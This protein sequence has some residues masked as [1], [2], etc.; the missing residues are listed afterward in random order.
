MGKAAWKGNMALHTRA[1][2]SLLLLASTA[3]LAA[4]A[5]WSH[6][7]PIARDMLDGY[8][9]AHGV[10]ASY[11]IRA[12]ETRR[13]R[14]EQ[15]RI[16]DPKRPDL[17]ADW[18]EM[19]VGPSLTG[20]S[21]KA[22][23]AGGVRLWGRQQGE[24]ISFGD[25]DRLLPASS[26][27]SGRLPRIDLVL[28]D[29][30]MAIESDYGRLGV[31]LDGQGNLRSGFEGKMAL[32][33]PDLRI[34]NCRARDVQAYGDV[35]VVGA[36]PT[37]TGPLRFAAL[38]CAG[39]R[40]GPG[41]LTLDAN[42]AE[43][44]RSWRGA[45]QLMLEGVSAPKVRIARL[46]GGGEF[47]GDAQKMTARFEAQARGVAAQTMQAAALQLA[48]KAEMGAR[49]GR[50][51][52]RATGLGITAGA[53]SVAAARLFAGFSQAP[54]LG[55]LAHQ[56]AG[57]VARVG[58]GVHAETNFAVSR[59]D[60][61]TS[62]SLGNVQLSAP[63]GAFITWMGKQALSFDAAGL[64]LAGAAR[65]GGGGFPAGQAQFAG[66]AG[67]IT[68][69]PYRATGAMLRA[70]PISF[71]L[72][73]IGVGLDTQLTLDGP[74]RN[75]RVT[76]LSFP[77]RL[78]PGQTM[79]LGCF[80]LR[81]HSLVSGALRMGPAQ[82][83]T[84]STRHALRLIA[85]RLTG[86]FAGAPLR[87]TSADIR[88]ELQPRRASLN[89]VNLS[90]GQGAETSHLTLDALTG[91]AQHGGFGGEIR[92]LAGQLSGI[93]LAVQLE[94]GRW[95]SSAAGLHLIG[96]GRVADR[97]AVPRFLPLRAA[98]IR[99][100]LAGNMLTA[101]TQLREPVSDQSIAT[102]ALQ[103]DLGH[104]RG[105]A[106]I[107]VPALVFS[108][109]LQPEA[110]TPVTKGVV[111]NVLGSI[112]GTGRIDWA[113]GQVRSS[114]RFQSS[115]LDFAAA[116]GPV[117]GLS[118]EI[119]FSDLIGLVTDGV[120]QARVA[121]INPGVNVTGGVIRYRLLPNFQLAV[122]GARWPFAGGALVLEPT[123]IDM[124]EAAQRHLTFRAEG[125][126]AAR[127]I[128]AMEFENIAATG[129]Y[130]GVLPMVF[131]AQGGRIEGG[132][133]VARGGG[134]VSYVGPVSN[135][136]LGLMGRFAF[137]ALKSMRYSR[138]AID[139]NGAIDGDVITRVSF[140]GVNQAPVAGGRTT[141]P[142]KI[143]G[144][145]NIPFI[146]NVTITAKFRQ[147]FDMAR[148]VNDPSVFINRAYPKL[149]ADPLALPP[150]RP[151]Q[152]LDRPK[153]P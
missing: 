39:V 147:L 130:D 21:V 70:T 121:A 123:I 138:L 144:A 100:H 109:T 16:G 110:L 44:A 45:A 146:F 8:L 61:L 2:L 69:A 127:F 150:D 24:K 48:A 94:R 54:I 17:V 13:Q 11:K 85:P 89:A 25:V 52:G 101:T 53:Q 134:T 7:E 49:G 84:C 107:D 5:L 78:L 74:V 92:G 62:A 139:L 35:S 58:Q 76:G 143:L 90:W 152:P 27:A 15:V 119:G 14:L 79:P 88:L 63:G 117:R 104:A 131:D 4:W 87:L 148:S 105:F 108:P 38:S 153:L 72:T 71:V 112:S 60:G 50:I 65:F 142:I 55:P 36:R 10:Q 132:R 116:F 82:V 67:Q 133:L 37:Y 23:R 3:V 33:G 19:D 122:E 124:S 102:L 28:E 111:A 75:G 73:P 145:N 80:A 12:I 9:A 56:L 93:P 103:H 29:A 81:M 83:R 115:G 22:I 149:Q 135:E 96:T 129:V 46:T 125:L 18:I 95:Q 106:Q 30:R 91:T 6:R 136:N 20:L 1:K 114:G 42:I 140:A 66:R 32:V 51:M 137:D 26:S 64:R 86:R 126:D 31:R 41:R 59:V 118:G 57:A 68:L 128:A 47:A 43:D 97:T 77:V 113:Q 40:T 120:Q 141:L 99:A 98:D 34:K 151:V